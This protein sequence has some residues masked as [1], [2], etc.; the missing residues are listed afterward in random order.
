MIFGVCYVL[1][2]AGVIFGGYEDDETW[3]DWLVTLLCALFWP[4]MVGV[5]L[6]SCRKPTRSG[7]K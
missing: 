7:R 1:I 2:A 3:D 4:V 5:A 6:P